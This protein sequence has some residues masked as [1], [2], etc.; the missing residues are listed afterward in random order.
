VVAAVATV[1]GAD[2]SVALR[3][4]ASMTALQASIGTLNDLVDAPSDAGHKPGKP[5]P[6]GLVSADL[7]RVIFVVTAGLGLGLAAVSGAGLLL[8]AGVVLAIGYAYDL[9]AKGTAWSW[10]PFAVGIP[11][12]PV[13]GW[14]GATGGLAEV[15]VVLVPAAMLGGAALAMANARA[16]LER[17]A[18]AGRGSIAAR[19]GDRRSWSVHVACWLGVAVLASAWLGDRG[20]GASS[21]AII[22]VTIGTGIVAAGVSLGREA[23]PAG[24]ERA[25]E[26]EAVGAAILAIGV[27]MTAAG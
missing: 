23:G 18:G 5:I 10:L 2:P 3:L 17:D 9:V 15:F 13:Y 26:L 21:L 22:L 20:S 11:I 19:L 12:L 4:G 24:R 7:A 6:A 14:F 8:L 25:W 27:L 16:D 1:A